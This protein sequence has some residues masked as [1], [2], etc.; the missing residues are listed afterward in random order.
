MN[1]RKVNIVRE[2]ELWHIE[3]AATG[4]RFCSTCRGFEGNC[5][6]VGFCTREELREA[7]RAYASI[8]QL[9]GACH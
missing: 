5:T 8:E 9:V 2:G 6:A 3:D 4:E 7:A 1:K